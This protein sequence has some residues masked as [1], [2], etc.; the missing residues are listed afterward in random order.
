MGGQD[1]WIHALCLCL[2]VAGRLCSR[3]QNRVVRS[4]ENARVGRRSL[5]RP[6]ESAERPSS[7]TRLVASKKDSMKPKPND[8]NKTSQTEP[9]KP[10]SVQRVVR[11]EDVLA[12]QSSAI[13]LILVN[14][15]GQSLTPDNVDK[16]HAE[17]IKEMREGP[18]AWAFSPTVG[19]SDRQNNEDS[20]MQT[21]S[22]ATRGGGSLHPV[23]RRQKQWWV[24]ERHNPQ[25]GI[26]HVACGQL[27]KTAAKKREA[28]S[29]GYNI[30]RPFDTEEKYNAHLDYLR[31]TG[32]RVQ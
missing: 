2:L 19:I 21:N 27:S 14:H 8:S 13:L 6:G 10:R 9:A 16:I 11:R 3:P 25:T 15:C 18:T 28:S 12:T 23:V 26:Y 20:N 5:E 32:E 30:M 24:K 7:L 4:M 22:T 17:I 31:E 29:Y 1:V